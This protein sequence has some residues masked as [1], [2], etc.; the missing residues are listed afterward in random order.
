MEDGSTHRQRRSVSRGE[1]TSEVVLAVGSCN[2]STKA[3]RNQVIDV[4][5]NSVAGA[6]FKPIKLKETITMERH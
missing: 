6:R 2:I 4:T 5:C 3:V 1:V